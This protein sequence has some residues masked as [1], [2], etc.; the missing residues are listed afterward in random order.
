MNGVARGA[1]VGRDIWDQILTHCRPLFWRSKP[2]N[3][4]NKWYMSV[5]Q[6]IEKDESWYYYWLGLDRSLIPATIQTL[7]KQPEDFFSK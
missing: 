1:G 5:A 3:N 4:I 7:K 6:G 2:D